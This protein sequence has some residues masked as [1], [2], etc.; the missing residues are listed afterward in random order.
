[1]KTEELKIGNWIQDRLHREVKVSEIRQDHYVF[2][3]SNG[4]KI[5]HNIKTASP[6]SIATEW[7]ER[8]GFCKDEEYD[9]TY[10]KSISLLNGFMSFGIDTHA[11]VVLFGGLEIGNLK[12]VHQLQ[13]LYFALTGEEL[14]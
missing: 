1:M 11:N 10:F 7:L 4:S 5:K 12:H 2:H 8:V 9:S 6:I 14:T 3:L 13:N